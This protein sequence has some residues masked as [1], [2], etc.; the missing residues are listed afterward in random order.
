VTRIQSS[1]STGQI[2]FGTPSNLG[3]G[4]IPQKSIQTFKPEK[5][6]QSN[7]VN[8]IFGKA[9]VDGPNGPTSVNVVAIAQG[10]HGKY[11]VVPPNSTP[12]AVAGLLRNTN[13]KVS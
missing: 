7:G 8:F 13:S 9:M 2:N 6:G 5:V 10:D 4:E 1:P 11:L 12:E 3:A